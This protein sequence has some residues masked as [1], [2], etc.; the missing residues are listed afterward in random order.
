MDNFLTFFTNGWHH[1]VDIKAYDHLLF[2]VTLCAA[3]KLK[4]WKQILIIVTAF[5]IGHSLTLIISSLDYVPSNPEIVELLI[6]ITIMFTAMSNV[7]N[8]KKE[9]KFSNKNIKYAIALIFGLIHGLAFA[10]GFKIMMFNS[11]IIIPLFAFNLGIEVGQLFI[12]AIFTIILFLYSRILNG[13][14]SK[15]NTFISGAGFGIA[16]TILIGM[17]T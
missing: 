7:I 11:D 8:Y 6:P 17:L 1:I 15:W 9:G 12:V 3:F 13:E 4:Q 5:T 2:V 16:A 10:S 14:H